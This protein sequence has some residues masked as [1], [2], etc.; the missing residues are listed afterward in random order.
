MTDE[1]SRLPPISSGAQFAIKLVAAQTPEKPPLISS[2]T[3]S[4]QFSQAIMALNNNADQIQSADAVDLQKVN[5]YREAIANGSYSINPH[6]IAERLLNL[7][8]YF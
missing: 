4:V 2:E 5:A 7:D 3:A 6:S 8:R 1:M